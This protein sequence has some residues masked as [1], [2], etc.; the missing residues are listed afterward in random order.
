MIEII[1]IGCRFP[2]GAHSPDTFWQF[3]KGQRTAIGEMPPDRWQAANFLSEAPD[4]PGRSCTFRA[5]WLDHIDRFDAAYFRLSPREALE[6]DP[7]Q[8]LTIEVAHEALFDANINPQALEDRRVG[9]YV[10]AGMAES[11]GLAFSDP[12]HMTAHTMS[13]NA[14]AVI[15][16]RLSYVLNLEGPSL[17]VDTAC[18]SALTALYLACQ[19]L[20]TGDCDLAL[21]A[22]VNAMLGPSPFVGLSHAHMLSPRGKCSPF[23]EQADGFVRGEGCGVVVLGRH[24]RP[25]QALRRVYAEIVGWNANEDGK[26]ASLTLPSGERQAA[27]IRRTLEQAGVAPEQVVY[28]E[29]HGTGTA[30]GDPI[31]ATAI[32]TAVVGQR[33]A[34]LAIGSVK[35]HTGHLE[36]G[37]GIVGL[38]KSALCLY[39]RQLVPTVGHHHWSPRIDAE[40]LRIRVPTAVEPLPDSE[41]GGDPA[42]G[43]CSYGFGGANAFALLKPAQH[44]P[45]QISA[46]AWCRVLPLSA[47]RRESV[48]Q[49]EA[50]FAAM[51]PTERADAVP[52]AGVAL[53]SLRHRRVRLAIDG[54]VFGT[55]AVVIDGEVKG[56]APQ[57]IFAYSG[58][59][60][61]HPSMGLPLYQQFA[62]FRHA[63]DEA[64]RLYAACSGNSLV[65]RYGF[66]RVDLDADSLSNV[67]VALPC[68]VLTQIGLTALLRDANVLPSAVLGHSTGEMTGAWAC[69]AIDLATLMRLTWE[70]AR[71]QHDMPPGAM[72]AWSADETYTSAV[73]HEL[74]LQNR[75]VVA[76]RNGE[77]ALTLSGDTQAIDQLLEYA[78][79]HRVRGAKLGVARAYHSPHVDA[80]L[81]ALRERLGEVSANATATAFCSTVADA[82]GVT[83]GDRLGK[84]YW[85]RNI[86]NAVDFAAGARAAAAH[87]DLFVEISP[88]PVLSSY[89]M[90]HQ[91]GVLCAQD[92][93]TKGD[94]ALLQCLAELFARG[95]DVRWAA[96]QAP[97]R[98]VSLPRVAWQH[99]APLRSVT[100]K[101]PSRGTPP[102]PAI[103]EASP[104]AIT[105]DADTHGFLSDHKVEGSVVMPGAGWVALALARVT[106]PLREIAFR[107]FLP[108]W[109]TRDR[110]TLEWT[111]EGER[112]EW[113]ADGSARWSCSLGATPQAGNAE[114]LQDILQR[115]STADP[116]RLYEAWRRHGGLDFGPSFRSLAEL[117]VG[118]AEAMAR[119]RVPET[120]PR[121][122]AGDAVLLDGCFQT[123]AA[124]L[125]LDVHGYVPMRIGALDG[126]PASAQAREVWC[127]ASLTDLGR[128]WA[129]GDLVIYAPDGA[130]IARVTALRLQRMKSS[131]AT[132][133]QAFTVVHELRGLPAAVRAWDWR[134]PAACLVRLYAADTGKR[135][136]RILD[137]SIGR[138]ALK[139]LQALPDSTL[140]AACMPYLISAA[141]LPADAPS[142][143]HPLQPDDPPEPLGFD[144]VIGSTGQRWMAPHG[145]LAPLD[146]VVALADHAPAPKRLLRACLFG[147]GREAWP[148]ATLTDDVE[149]ATVV[150]DGRQS[151]Q[152]ASAL[153][154][155]INRIEPAPTLV[156]V[157]EEDEGAPPSPL[158]GFARAARNELPQLDICA[159][160]LPARLD[161][162]AAAA[163]LELCE[164]GFGADPELRW[165]GNGW[166]VPRLVPI[167]SLPPPVPTGALRLEIA[168]PGQLA[169][170]R[171]RS[172]HTQNESLRADEIRI[173]VQAAAL[174]FKDVMVALGMLPGYRPVLGLEGCGTIIEA[175]ADVPTLYPE[176]QPGRKVMALTL[177]A[178]DGQR[179]A[180]FGTTAIVQARNAVL[181][182]EGVD[183]MAAASF[184]GVYTTAWQALHHIAR[185]QPGE[186]VLIHSA[187][188]G[189][190]QAAVQ[191][192]RALDAQIIASAGSEQKRSY[193]QQTL[194]VDLVFDSR[195]PAQFVETIHAFTQG[196]GVEVVLNSLAGDG[197]RESLRCLAPGG[198]HVEIGKRDILDDAALGLLA[199]K[200]NISF[201]SVHIDG[202]A[203]THPQRLRALV[204]ECTARLGCGKAAALPATVFAASQAFDAF[205]LMAAGDHMGKVVLAMPARGDGAALALQA[206]AE[207][208]AHALFGMH[209]TLLVTGGTGGIGLA[210]ARF[211]A[212]RGAGRLLLAGRRAHITRR[213]ALAIKALQRDYPRCHIEPIALDLRE[214][215]PLEELLAREPNLT[216][217]F[218]LATSFGAEKATEI[219]PGSL[220]TW[221]VKAEAAWRLHRL[222]AAHKLRHFV[223]FSS[224]GGLHGNTQQ[225]V[226]V[227][228]NAALHE[229][230]RHRRAQRLPGIA[231]DL[232]ITLGAGRLS[233][234]RYLLE[235][236]LNTGKGFAAISSADLEGWLERLFANPQ[237]CP[238]VVALDA[239][240]WRGYWNLA[241]RRRAF[242]AHLVPRDALATQPPKTSTTRQMPPAT[243]IEQAAREQVATLLGARADEIELDTPLA[244][245]GLDSLGAVEL[246]SW[247][248]DRYGVAISQTQLLTGATARTLVEAVLAGGAVASPMP[249]QS[250]DAR[251]IEQDVRQQVATLLGAKAGEIEADAPL[252]ELGL[253]S[254]GA[255]E[256][257][258]WMQ[259]RYAVEISQT[260]L[261]TGASTRS[262][263]DA[264]A[265]QK[266]P[267]HDAI[268]QAPALVEAPRVA[269]A[270]APRPDITVNVSSTP[271]AVAAALN[272]P[273]PLSLVSEPDA[274]MAVPLRSF[275]PARTEEQVV[276]LPPALTAAELAPLIETL[277]N[278]RQTLVLRAT[279][280]SEHFCLGMDLGEASF[281]DA[282]MSEGL[283]RFAELSNLLEAAP[284][285]IICVVEGACRG[286][287]MLFPSLASIVLATD[288]A[289][290]GFP[291][292]RRGG[293]PGVVSVA[294]QRRLRAADCRRLMLTGDAIDAR[295]AR[296]YGLVDVMGSKQDIE[297][298]LKRL[299]MRLA[300]IEPTLLHACQTRCPAP[301]MASAL[302]TMGAL[303]A[304]ANEATHDAQ[305]LVRVQHDAADGVAV[306]EL[307]DALHSNAIDAPMARDLHRAMATV[308]QLQAVRAVI[309]QGD[310]AHFCV[311][312]NPYRF[313]ATM[314]AMPVLTAAHQVFDIYR[315]FTRMRELPVPVICVVHGKV[316]GG[317]LAAMLNADYR[318]CSA[319]ASF[320]VGN[321]PRGVCPG[322]LMSE[323]L[324]QLVGRRWA[325]ELYL[326]DYTL[327]AEQALELGLVNEVHPTLA[328]AQA[329]AR[330]MARHIAQHPAAGVR[331]TTALMRPPVDLARL[332]RESLGIARCVTQGDAFTGTWQGEVRPWVSTAAAITPRQASNTPLAPATPPPAANPPVA[333]L[334]A[335]P[336][337]AAPVRAHNAG[338]IAMEL[339]FPN[340]MVLQADMER[341]HGCPGKYTVGLG[342]EAVTFCGDDEDTVSMALTVVQRLMERYGID[343]SQI[344]RLE[345]GT[346]SQV[347]RSKSIKSYV[348]QLFEAHG[349]SNIEGVDTYNACYG[350]TSALFNTIAWC[351]SEAWDGRYGLVVCVDIADLNEQQS[352]LNGAAAVAML[353]GPDAALVMKP[354]RASHM[355]HRWDFYKPVG[356]A[357]PFPLMRDGKHSIDLYTACLDACQRGLSERLG[358][359]LLGTHDHFVFHC[360]STYLIKR[361]F[362]R[363]IENEAPALSLR[364]KRAMFETMVQPSTYLTRQIG[365]TY[366]ASVYV[367]LYSLLLQCH[368]SIVGKRIGVYS[369][370]SGSSAS[371]YRM[372]VA[373]PPLIDRDIDARL[374]ARRR[375]EPIPFIALTRQY[376][377][378]YGRFDYVPMAS[379]GRLDGVFYL[380]RVDAWGQRTYARHGQSAVPGVSSAGSND[381]AAL[382]EL[383]GARS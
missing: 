221:S 305:P 149:A 131:R 84:D 343:W 335:S 244:E 144:L 107:R 57:L 50:D 156:F 254:L 1:G 329:A 72:A 208:I 338:I 327:T 93:R 87:G 23:D 278:C 253:D 115:C 120:V 97:T 6:M 333:V 143:C 197:L 13:G 286:G 306:I 15:A 368:D 227:A 9:V 192:A 117:R 232:P 282:T 219:E 171:W 138:I 82:T 185:L 196:R 334:P 103:A 66:G 132:M 273:P 153:L 24:D 69:G 182:P 78:R 213:A 189:V 177:T 147:A 174:N 126:W 377:S 38:I 310:G 285:P 352:Y 109:S 159:I 95:T 383:E 33:R 53:P 184:L 49:L 332:A 292:I 358:S 378:A 125:G 239:P 164:Q 26:T 357:D 98:F 127:H 241:P 2:G 268:A 32:A 141:P 318:I 269:H 5:G 237:A 245:M 51:A 100:W 198:R 260:H 369:Y 293:L 233:E 217:V 274:A 7:Q 64:D 85:L 40:A 307:N 330:Q 41:L 43:V 365:S 381:V 281:G 14:L 193:L 280:G 313:T 106:K 344:G 90:A 94:I 258:S 336:A 256:L 303:G 75:I 340:H 242:F 224:L 226:Y 252:A 235:L 160:G 71:A 203:E 104:H 194:G 113:Q 56:K 122:W 118:D 31:E 229:L 145:V 353:I 301:D 163:L 27:V 17:A 39:H 200:N 265:A 180:L 246:L 155:R 325:S 101:V 68:I 211:L 370:G 111:H 161:G 309:V 228:A 312:V 296:R 339:Y 175:G 376:S 170:L 216:G 48:A 248:Q 290:F 74:G 108:L 317:G 354:E 243:D 209:E 263:V 356:W 8:R 348:M 271:Q 319:D 4:E 11:L 136:L 146:D 367:N 201:H 259:N 172:V 150:I 183:D 360:T 129:E 364:E 210:L 323:S 105:L 223:L 3:L 341:H 173:E 86:R 179:C 28:I 29:A 61:H 114:A 76:A 83:P 249:V 70:R 167:D 218:H 331:A 12:E 215:G 110:I 264:I 128:D 60:S 366:T 112:W 272:T 119:V 181:K 379:K 10:G 102:S 284:M 238:P 116:A 140:Q 34:P 311:G 202:L 214:D 289:T 230:A 283:E 359:G 88:V 328:E 99:D 92:R 142:W 123:L 321:L 204:E 44:M 65:E 236:Q 374:K 124:L 275:Q 79:Q 186:T 247:L 251:E 373:K 372:E 67:L 382:P 137:L 80:V 206:Q 320:N 351:Q 21:V 294:A 371:F 55:G 361:A 337:G 205:R 316:V 346:E 81:P 225:A 157:I 187:A 52:W 302:V 195:R 25:F 322:M 261:L 277:R 73:L 152:D 178:Q 250:V 154:A 240:R 45:G 130:Q 63:V 148:A 46:P 298:E 270:P 231:I 36:T 121:G 62:A 91:Q 190:G 59:G 375:Y 16:N 19:S 166:Q 342:Q 54:D 288:E 362:D 20:S 188:G 355:L 308:Q 326:H 314:K 380:L 255:V 18:S 135:S 30:A 257:L 77:E 295:T 37:A 134:D 315:A 267:A 207:P 349:C 347:D 47:P 299:L 279:P 168:Q 162:K 363:V 304:S 89:L 291:E 58:Q 199:L 262:L 212:E 191:V 176:L 276:H 22:G 266:G 234:T 158:W 151:L 165:D 96:V 300:T 220:E 139:T 169:S 287:G 297:Q 42:I 133:P 35:G 324:Q 222:T 345:V 350:G